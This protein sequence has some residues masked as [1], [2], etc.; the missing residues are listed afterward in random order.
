MT[1]G[2]WEGN[3]LRC[4]FW[5]LLFSAIIWLVIILIIVAVTE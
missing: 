3:L 4:V 2:C 1:P 5:T